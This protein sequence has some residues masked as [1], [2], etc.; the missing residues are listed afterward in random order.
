M[1]ADL[2]TRPSLLVRLRDVTDG[3][4]WSRFVTLYTPL[5]F[6][7]CRGRGLSET[8]AGDVAQEVLKAVAGAIP[9]FDY[10]P[11]RS[12]FRNWLFT[13]VRSK[14]NNFFAAQARHP[15]RAGETTFQHFVEG[16]PDRTLEEA[17]QLEYQANLVRW[18]ARQIQVEFKPQTW[19]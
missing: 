17:W 9:R 12:S 6:A 18:A 1:A 11:Q 13:V 4:A 3:A 8:D 5:I 16:E 7:V 19:D 15:P 14:L 2:Q 10:D